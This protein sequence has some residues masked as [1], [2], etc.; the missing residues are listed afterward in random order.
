M[1]KIYQISRVP[2]IVRKYFDI[3]GKIQGQLK[4]QKVITIKNTPML[5][6]ISQLDSSFHSLSNDTT[7]IEFGQAVYAQRPLENRRPRPF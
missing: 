7:Y 4:G 1:E 6:Q 2:K 5:K 3:R